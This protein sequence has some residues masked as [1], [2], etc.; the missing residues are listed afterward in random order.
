M[1]SDVNGEQT[2]RHMENGVGRLREGLVDEVV[3]QILKSV[4]TNRLE[5][6]RNLTLTSMLTS[7]PNM[8]CRCSSH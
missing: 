2:T 7:Y 3:Q 1:A 6:W 4:V 8:W 5:T